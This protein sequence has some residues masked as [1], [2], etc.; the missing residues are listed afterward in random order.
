MRRRNAREDIHAWA[1]RMT[2][3]AEGLEVRWV[4]QNQ[5]A[6]PSSSKPGL[7]YAVVVDPD[8]HGLVHCLCHCQS[9]TCRPAQPIPCRHAA[10]VI[11]HLVDTGYLR[12]INGLA[13]R[14]ALGQLGALLELGLNASRRSCLT[15]SHP[16]ISVVSRC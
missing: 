4:A 12:R 1:T 10:A 5:Y 16:W 6:V 2:E 8:D 3:L 13:Y 7:F 14:V 15:A 11:S 9:G